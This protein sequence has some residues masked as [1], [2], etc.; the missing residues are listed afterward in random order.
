M[1]AEVRT[2]QGHGVMWRP[3]LTDPETFAIQMRGSIRA[4]REQLDM[5]ETMA[6]AM[7]MKEPTHE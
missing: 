4:M 7:A 5:L 6:R 2:A 3:I 1:Q